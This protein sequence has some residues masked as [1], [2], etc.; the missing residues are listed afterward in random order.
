MENVSEISRG[1]L[2]PLADEGCSVDEKIFF[3]LIKKR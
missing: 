3:H 1:W 2:K